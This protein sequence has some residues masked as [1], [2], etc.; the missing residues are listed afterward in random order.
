ML[1]TCHQR[2]HSSWQILYYTILS[3]TFMGHIHIHL[4]TGTD[5]SELPLVFSES[6]DRSWCKSL[7]VDSFISLLLAQGTQDDMG[8]LVVI[9]LLLLTQG[10]W[11]SLKKPIVASWIVQST[12]L[13]MFLKILFIIISSPTSSLRNSLF[14]L[15]IPITSLYAFLVFPRRAAC[16]T[17][18]IF[19]SLDLPWVQIFPAAPCSQKHSACATEQIAA[20]FSSGCWLSI[21]SLPSLSS[22]SSTLRQLVY[23]L[24]YRIQFVLGIWAKRSCLG[25]FLFSG[26][27]SSFNKS[28][29]NVAVSRCR[30]AYNLCVLCCVIALEWDTADSC[31]DPKCFRIRCQRKQLVGVWSS[32]WE[33]QLNRGRPKDGHLLHFVVNT[34]DETCISVSMVNRNVLH[35]VVPLPNPWDVTTRSSWQIARKIP[36]L[37]DTFHRSFS[38]NFLWIYKEA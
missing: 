23:K 1:P 15:D 24:I 4:L 2:S 18:F 32:S 30:A 35:L 17:H 28:R 36:W 13:A 14:R 3:L 26:L 27:T 8:R 7:C 9:V 25:V 21:S 6:P 38:S 11:I 19:L 29:V 31:C 33:L 37:C 34:T 12:F 22:Y 16:P 5:P 20:D 10:N